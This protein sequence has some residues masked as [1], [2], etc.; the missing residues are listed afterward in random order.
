MPCYHPLDAWRGAVSPSSGKCKLVFKRP[1]GKFQPELQV[2]CGRCIGCRLE[3]SRQWA[4][5]C[6]HEAS[7]HEFNCFVTLTYS[8]DKLPYGGTLVKEDL[9][10]FQKRLNKAC[11]ERWGYPVPRF[12][13]CGEYGEQLS[14]PHYHALLFG[15]DFPDK[16]LFTRRESGDLYT[17]DMLSAVWGRGHC[18]VGALTFESAAYVARYVV[19]KLEEA[20]DYVRMDEYGQVHE[21]IPE[22]VTM[23]RG[24]RGDLGGIGRGWFER[25]S[26]EVYPS[27]EV[28]VRGYLSKPP[29]YYDVL[30]QEAEPSV[31]DYVRLRRREAAD[32]RVADGTPARLRVREKV[33]VSRVKTLRRSLDGSVT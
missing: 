30:Q 26:N 20:S 22:F 32:K 12:F 25:W 28:V 27:D 8:D 24:G 1:D 7:L 11:R 9:Q 15:L 18:T 3:Y 21:V 29:R 31:F 5:R 17:S 23:S 2:P 14:R 33:R 19:K 16:K 10:K 13:Q 6:M 4:V